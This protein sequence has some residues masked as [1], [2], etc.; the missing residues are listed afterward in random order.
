MV[1]LLA[2]RLMEQVW[3][4]DVLLPIIS[5]AHK[6][7]SSSKTT[8]TQLRKSQTQELK[9]VYIHTKYHPRGLQRK[10]YRNIW[11]DTLGK[12]LPNTP[13]T[14]AVARLRNLG[15]RLCHS[16]LPSV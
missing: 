10:D 16:R 4:I 9:T 2:T 7:I 11:N 8:H 5:A 13:V 12:V 1:S 3:P 6:Y 15:D 14:I